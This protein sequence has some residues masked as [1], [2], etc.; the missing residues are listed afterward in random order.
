MA[1][2]HSYAGQ[3][4]TRDS[5]TPVS[6]F[7]A[8]NSILTLTSVDHRKSRPP[9]AKQNYQYNYKNLVYHVY[10]FSTNPLPKVEFPYPTCVCCRALHTQKISHDQRQGRS[11]VKSQLVYS[12]PLPLPAPQCALSRSSPY[13]GFGSGSTINAANT[14]KLVIRNMNGTA[15]FV[16]RF[17]GYSL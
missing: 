8:F 7:T 10:L 2:Q 9:I 11:C 5:L 15:I 14:V 1:Q 13:L 3:T 6:P 12:T 17:R 16:F 4:R